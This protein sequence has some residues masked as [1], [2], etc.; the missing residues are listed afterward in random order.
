LLSTRRKQRRPRRKQRRLPASTGAAPVGADTSGPLQ[1]TR[2]L[3]AANLS[4][5]TAKQYELTMDF[6][7]EEQKQRR[8]DI[9]IIVSSCEADQRNILLISG[10]IWSWLAT[11]TDKIH[12]LYKYAVWV[13]AVLTFLFII[14][15]IFN[16]HTIK[17][18]ARYTKKLEKLFQLPDGYGWETYL[19]TGD[20]YLRK[21]ETYLIRGK[22]APDRSIDHRAILTT[23]FFAVLLIANLVLGYLFWSSLHSDVKPLPLIQNV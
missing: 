20:N 6:I 16:H 18:I 3:D 8:Q 12:E 5:K 17:N 21:G 22:D 7:K 15:W 11:N 19:S 1:G 9:E 14:R 23:I 10:A 13:P 2:V 4:D